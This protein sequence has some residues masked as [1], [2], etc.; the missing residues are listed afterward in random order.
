MKTYF[1]TE[2][3]NSHNLPSLV[4]HELQLAASLNYPAIS[5]DRNMNVIIEQRNSGSYWVSGF[6]LSKGN[7]TKIKFKKCVRTFF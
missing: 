7:S 4:L 3:S 6:N 2:T 1:M 5:K